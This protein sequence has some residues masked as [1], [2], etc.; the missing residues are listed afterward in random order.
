MACVVGGV[1]ARGACMAGGMH[2]RGACMVDTTRYGDTVNE[3]AVH[4]LVKCILV[5]WFFFLFFVF[6]H[7]PKVNFGITFQ[8]LK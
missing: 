3:W 2:G 7:G 5:C 8:K 6:F 4:I 1:H